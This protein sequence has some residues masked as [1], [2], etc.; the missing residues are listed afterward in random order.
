MG[1]LQ[2]TLGVSIL[3]C[4]KDLDDLGVPPCL[5]TPTL[6]IPKLL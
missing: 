6:D 2:I 4:S 5:G 3:K 1:D